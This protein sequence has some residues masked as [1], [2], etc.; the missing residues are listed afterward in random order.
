MEYLQTMV[1]IQGNFELPP[2]HAGVAGMFLLTG[3]KEPA[4]ELCMHFCRV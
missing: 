1:G 2:E 3:Q 4:A